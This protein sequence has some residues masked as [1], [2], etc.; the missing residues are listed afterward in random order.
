MWCVL[1]KI[2][3]I[4]FDRQ[5]RP[6]FASLSPTTRHYRKVWMPRIETLPAHAR[7]TLHSAATACVT[8]DQTVGPWTQCHTALYGRLFHGTGT[9]LMQPRVPVQCTIRYDTRCYFNVRSKVSLIYR[10]ETTTKNC[11]REKLKSTK[12]AYEVTVKVWGIM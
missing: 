9:E 8:S 1:S 12:I 6:P 2:N 3:L 11:K 5:H 10:T 4:C 7:S